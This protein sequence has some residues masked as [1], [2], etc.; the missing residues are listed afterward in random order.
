MKVKNIDRYVGRLS[1]PQ[2][3]K[4]VSMKIHTPKMGTWESTGTPKISE[5]DCRGQNTSH[6]RV[7]YIIGKLLKFRCLK[8]A[9]MNHLDIWNTSYGKRKGRESNWQFESR[10]LKVKNRPNPSVCRW[11]ATYRWNFFD[12]SYNFALDLIPIRGLSKEL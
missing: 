10:P 7:I 8:W 2:S 4:S 6:W 9:C 1:Q 3:W 11:S 12:K 5:S